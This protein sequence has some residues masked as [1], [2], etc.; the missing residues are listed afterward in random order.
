MRR[1]KANPAANAPIIG[2]IPPTSTRKP[3]R[4]TT[5]STNIKL[6]YF[7]ESALLKNHLAIR[8]TKTKTNTENRPR[9]SISLNKKNKSSPPSLFESISA[10]II[11]TAVSVSIVPPTVIATA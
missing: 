11:S 4:N 8:G 2:S 6:V 1:F 9:E 3:D 10:K 7:S 5:K